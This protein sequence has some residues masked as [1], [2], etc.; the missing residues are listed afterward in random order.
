METQRHTDRMLSWF[1]Q[2]KVTRV[3]LAIRRSDGTMIWHPD[4]VLDNL[5]LAWARAENVRRADVYIR[6]ARGFDWPVLFLDDV[7]ERLA[8]LV[9]RK[10]QA[11]VIR[12]SRAGGCH[13]W[14]SSSKALGEDAR[15]RA[16]SWLAHMIG[17]DLGSTSGEHLGRLPG[18]KNWKRHGEWVNVLDNSFFKPLWDPSVS[19][20]ADH[21][22]AHRSAKSGSNKRRALE[23]STSSESEKEWGWVCGS[24]EAGLDPETVYYCLVER[25][26]RREKKDADRYAQRTVR[27]AILHLRR[28]S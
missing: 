27:K 5:P 6:P 24:L 26:K 14:L 4:R 16:Q 18:F 25:A 19:P 8:L 12:T 10:Y 9:P 3:D 17:A 11:L 15:R 7:D 2:A 28:Q 1:A 20:R 23:S 22:N 13:V 21:T